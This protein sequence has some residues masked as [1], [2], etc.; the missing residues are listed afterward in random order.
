MTKRVMSR[1]MLLASAAVLVIVSSAAALTIIGTP[2]D[3]TIIGLDTT[4]RRPGIR[5]L[6]RQ[7]DD[8]ATC[9]ALA[10][11]RP[12]R[13]RA[14]TTTTVAAATTHGGHDGDRIRSGDGNDTAGGGTGDDGMAGGQGD[15]TQTWRCRRRPDLRQQGR[16]H[17]VRELRRRPAL[18]LVRADVEAE[19]V[20]TLVGGAGD[21]RFHAR[22][23]EA[24]DID[25]GPGH[26]GARLDNVDVIVDATEADPNGSCERVGRADPRR[27][28]EEPEVDEKI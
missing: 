18:G 14:K 13:G 3:D 21:D 9:D 23:G 10:R 5:A 4:D 12:D 8:R 7:G 24:D 17:V 27:R 1:A 11:Q 19:G 28:D 16:G 22:D 2:G 15:D 26:D 25:C 6:G 20:D